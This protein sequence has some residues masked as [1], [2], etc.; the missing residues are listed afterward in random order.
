[1]N[2]LSEV[3]GGGRIVSSDGHVSVGSALKLL[4]PSIKL[5]VSDWFDDNLA[6]PNT[7]RA[8]HCLNLL[9]YH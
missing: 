7:F 3:L 4:K 9:Q 1:M 5:L 6:F 8:K 2:A